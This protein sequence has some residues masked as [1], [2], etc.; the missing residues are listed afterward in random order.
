MKPA[1]VA[2]LLAWVSVVVAVAGLWAA[3]QVKNA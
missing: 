1:Q 2:L 3:Y